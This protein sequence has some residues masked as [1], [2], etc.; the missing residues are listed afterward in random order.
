M[1]REPSKEP[2]EMDALITGLDTYAQ[3]LG[4]FDSAQEAHL[5][6]LKQKH[7]GLLPAYQPL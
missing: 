5:E 6:A 2:R 7:R 3:R 1:L 4:S